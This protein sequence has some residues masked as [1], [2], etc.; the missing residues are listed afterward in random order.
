MMMNKV[1]INKTNNPNYGYESR[2]DLFR[3]VKQHQHDVYRVML[4]LSYCMRERGANHDWSKITYFDD[5]AKDTLER[6]D[7]PDFK[8][9]KWY[10]IHTTKERHH[11]NANVPDNV[12]LLDLV[13]MMVDCICA[14]KSRSGCV[15]F[16]FLELNKGV[17]EDAYWN[18]IKLIDEN[19]ILKDGEK[20]IKK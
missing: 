2:V 5:F 1:K 4:E 6:L 17:L 9:R 18:T 8:S 12:N 14:G 10:N 19:V 3:D 15:D 20:I 16:S 7:T 13:E 11:V